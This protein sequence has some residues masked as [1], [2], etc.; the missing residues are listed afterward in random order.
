ME[1]QA[2]LHYCGKEAQAFGLPGTAS[3][4]YENDGALHA[5]LA[6][7][8]RSA[9]PTAMGLPAKSV[10]FCVGLSPLTVD[11]LKQQQSESTHLD[12]RCYL[13]GGLIGG[14]GG[15]GALLKQEGRKRT[16]KKVTNFGSCR[17]LNGRRLRHV[18]DE[19]NLQKWNKLKRD[20]NK[21]QDGNNKK[22][23]KGFGSAA[24][25]AFQ[26][27][28][29]GAS[30]GIEGWHGEVPKWSGMFGSS[31]QKRKRPMNKGD[32][33]EGGKAGSGSGIQSRVGGSS[34]AVLGPS[35]GSF[36]EAGANDVASAVLAG[37]RRKKRKKKKRTEGAIASGE[38][39]GTAEPAGA[40][41]TA[42]KVIV[43][44]LRGELALGGTG[45]G[46]GGRNYGTAGVLWASVDDGCKF[47]E[48]ELVSNGIM[49]IGWA[50]TLF[51]GDDANG[52]GVGDDANSWGYD[53]KRKKLWHSGE[54]SP[55]G[56]SESCWKEND[57]VG[58]FINAKEGSLKFFLNGSLLGSMQ[59]P[60][61][62]LK[63]G[64]YPALSLEK[65]EM[66]RINV[67]QRPFR[68]P[69]SPKDDGECN[70]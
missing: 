52:D 53:G 46:Q 41:G 67:G 50:T 44:C 68:F 24:K 49:Q 7:R 17:D 5:Y 27:F 51:V 48:V 21:T 20:Q 30:S 37:F 55:F 4:I 22:K 29:A 56:N 33:R 14:K 42:G 63:P 61:D 31:S 59:V 16:G 1:F 12:I 32:R 58:C 60:V 65:D 64:V 45:E 10:R 28:E 8:L 6:G 47:Y 57:I 23:S 2:H 15:F 62:K 39:A 40:V 69:F 36:S 18:N 66:V 34:S 13:R 26:E 19:K 35:A 3:G 25:Q 38:S 70:K 54:T 11:L 9:F 43:S